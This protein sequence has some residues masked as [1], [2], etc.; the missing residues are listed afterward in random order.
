MEGG[1]AAKLRYFLCTSSITRRKF[2]P[3]MRRIF[4]SLY[5][6][7]SSRRVKFIN[8]DAEAQPVM[9]PSP[10]KSVP[11][12]TCSMPMTFTMWFRCSMASLMVASPFLRRIRHTYIPVPP[13][14][15]LPMLS[16]GHP[17]D[18]ADGRKGHGP[19]N[20]RLRSVCR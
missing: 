17:S 1:C 11:I 16:I 3:Q 20:E 10:S 18:C 6:S 7:N 12:P 5:L 2:P 15:W 9:P 4:S 8:S 13:P 14:P 19:K